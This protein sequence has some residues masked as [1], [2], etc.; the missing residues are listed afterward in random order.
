MTTTTLNLNGFK[1]N[2][3]VS[4]VNELGGVATMKTFSQRSKAV[5]RLMKLAAEKNVELDT[6]FDTEGNKIVAKVEA[7]VVTAKPAKKAKA[8]KVKAE[9]KV[10]IR[11]V[12]EALLV[13][14]TDGDNGL[15]YE[16]ILAEVKAQFPD[17]KTTVG[18][19][20]WY[21]AHMREAGVVIPKRARAV[22]AK[23]AVVAEET[24]VAA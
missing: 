18:C 1:M 17:A 14:T 10:S 22:V 3:L 2:T 23:A 24:P 7:P 5:A 20:R 11:S 9:K 8:E 16:E 21:A 4:M 6:V 19:L 12:A 15:S 13:K